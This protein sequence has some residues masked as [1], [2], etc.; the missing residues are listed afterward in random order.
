ME[1]SEN[2]NNQNNDFIQNDFVQNDFHNS[3]EQSG[4]Q[5]IIEN[6]QNNMFNMNND[7]NNFESQNLSEEEQ[8]R[9]EARKVEADE[10][11][12]KI[13]EKIN[14]ELKLKNEIK[15]KAS[16]FLVDFEQKRLEAKELKKKQNINDEENAK[17][18]KELIKEG[19]KNPWEFVVQ[20]IDLKDS[21]Y[22]GSK[23]ITR[24]KEVIIERKNDE[25]K[26]K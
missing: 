6:N 8:K 14:L 25:F 11:R 18:E 21:D 16:A 26:P 4:T 19:K 1:F 23:D 15:E 2:N 10:R 24:M 17:K 13:E 3:N 7:I 20:N 12:K 5:N 9:I 22:K